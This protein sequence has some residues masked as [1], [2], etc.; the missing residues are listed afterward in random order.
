MENNNNP[1]LNA[2][3][4]RKEL[5]STHPSENGNANGYQLGVYRPD[6]PYTPEECEEIISKLEALLDGELD[7]EKQKEVEAMIRSCEF[8]M[9]Q[10]NIETSMRKIVKTALKNLNI[11]KNLISTIKNLIKKNSSSPTQPTE[12]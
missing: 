3:S 5:F 1:N 12:A 8:C 4:P 11:S 7:P 10:Y 9:E 6:S 2:I